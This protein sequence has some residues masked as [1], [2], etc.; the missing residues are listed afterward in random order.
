MTKDNPYYWPRTTFNK[1]IL[2]AKPATDPCLIVIFIV[3]IT[4]ALWGKLNIL[5]STACTPCTVFTVIIL[6]VMLSPHI[7]MKQTQGRLL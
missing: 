2:H 4:V 7:L 6:A 5:I 3:D 1:R